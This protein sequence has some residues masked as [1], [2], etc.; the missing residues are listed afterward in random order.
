M[1]LER[2]GIILRAH[3]LKFSHGIVLRSLKIAFTR[4]NNM[5][6]AA[7]VL[8]INHLPCKPGV[9]GLDPF[10]PVCR[11]KLWPHLHMILAVGTLN[12]NITTK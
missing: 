2:F 8:W 9:A 7:M 11:M 3:K 1:K 6:G 5:V 10:L 4:E 12:T